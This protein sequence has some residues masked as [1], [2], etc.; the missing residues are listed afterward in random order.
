MTK[1]VNLSSVAEL[2]ELKFCICAVGDPQEVIAVILKEL[3]KY[4]ST[5]QMIKYELAI[6]R[7]LRLASDSEKRK[8]TE[9]LDHLNDDNIWVLSH[10][11]LK[12]VIDGR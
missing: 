12:G 10:A 11:D 3:R 4:S 7:G 2:Q 9:K 5:L 8:I 1:Y 6:R